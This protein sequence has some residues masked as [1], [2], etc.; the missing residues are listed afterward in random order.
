MLSSFILNLL[1]FLFV[2][3]RIRFFYQLG[4]GFNFFREGWIRTRSISAGSTTLLAPLNFCCII[5][6]LKINSML[7]ANDRKIQV[8][9]SR[10]MVTG[11]FPSISIQILISNFTSIQMQFYFGSVFRLNIRIRIQHISKNEICGH[12]T[13]FPF[14]I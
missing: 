6:L 4:S 1:P 12:Q 8:R 14:K 7:N 5:C 9:V 2:R 10:N 13:I 11:I 3:N